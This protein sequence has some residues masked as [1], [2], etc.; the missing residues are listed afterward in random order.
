MS[1]NHTNYIHL[2]SQFEHPHVH[3]R[4]VREF[5]FREVLKPTHDRGSRASSTGQDREDLSSSVDNL[6]QVHVHVYTVCVQLLHMHVAPHTMYV[7]NNVFCAEIANGEIP[8]I[9]V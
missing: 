5:R 1:S 4:R 8:I 3:I 7:Y 2:Q 6:V 9:I